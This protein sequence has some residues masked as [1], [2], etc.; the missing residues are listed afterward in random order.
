MNQQ[1]INIFK[2]VRTYPK[3]G[4]ESDQ[5]LE[6]ESVDRNRVVLKQSGESND[7]DLLK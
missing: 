4:C 3:S 7:C 2:D 5:L 6:R 1:S